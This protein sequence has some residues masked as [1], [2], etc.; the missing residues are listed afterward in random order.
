[1]Y[2]KVL[3]FGILLIVASLILMHYAKT[4]IQQYVV[5]STIHGPESVYVGQKL[6]PIELLFDLK[7]RG[8]F[9]VVIGASRA[10]LMKLK[11][12]LLQNGEVIKPISNYTDVKSGIMIMSFRIRNPGVYRVYITSTLITPTPI[13]LTCFFLSERILGGLE[14]I[15]TLNVVSTVLLIAGIGISAFGTIRGILKK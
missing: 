3:G 8:Q 10:V 11:I 5:Q 4:T 15:K 1:M 12:D 9:A 2:W 6:K 7:S 13:N 14:S